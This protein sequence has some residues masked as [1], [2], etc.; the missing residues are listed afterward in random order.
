MS[1]L[2]PRF[3]LA[4]LQARIVAANASPVGFVGLL[5]KAHGEQAEITREGFFEHALHA[6]T[7]YGNAV[8]GDAATVADRLEELFEETGSRCGFMISLSQAGPRSL[9]ENLVD[10]LVPEL[11]R[12]GRHRTAY[13]GRTLRENLAP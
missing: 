11:R 4:E 9:L 3:S 7:G 1:L 12:R 10:H 5:A 2:P 13:E 6:A 8:V